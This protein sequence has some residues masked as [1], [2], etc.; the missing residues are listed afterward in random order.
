MKREDQS[1]N[2]S[3]LLRRRNKMPMAG[4]TETKYGA[5]TGGKAI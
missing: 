1:M 4:V 5:E 2:T 3:I